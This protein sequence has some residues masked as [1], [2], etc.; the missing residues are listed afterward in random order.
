MLLR[1]K[2]SVFWLGMTPD[3]RETREQCSSCHNIAPSLS[4]MLPVEPVVPAYPFPHICVDYFDLHSNHIWM[5]VDRFSNWFNVYTGNSGEGELVGI[6][7]RMFWDLG[8]PE[9][10]MSDRGPEFKAERFKKLMEQ[11]RVHHRKSSVRFAHAN[12]RAELAVKTAKRLLRENISPTGELDNIKVTRAPSNTGTRQI[13][14]PDC[15]QH[16]CSLEDN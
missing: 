12:T 2:L 3:I 9:T 11:Y 6:M 7:H 4:N 13:E 14:T 15:P 8:V 16:T 10:L 1:A 5:V